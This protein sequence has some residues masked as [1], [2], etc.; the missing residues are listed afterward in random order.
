MR[1]VD[2]NERAW[3]K[4]TSKIVMIIVLEDVVKM[5]LWALLKPDDCL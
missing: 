4:E 1:L 3:T 5:L 2:Y